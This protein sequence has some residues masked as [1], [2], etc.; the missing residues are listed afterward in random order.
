LRKEDIPIYQDI[1]QKEALA[2][3]QLIR[4][5]ENNESSLEGKYFHAQ[6]AG[7]DYYLAADPNLKAMTQ[8]S[9]SF[10][11]ARVG[12]LS[13]S[14]LGFPRFRNVAVVE[15]RDVTLAGGLYSAGPLSS[16][17]NREGTISAIGCINSYANPLQGIHSFVSPTTTGDKCGT[18]MATPAV[19]GIAAYLWSVRPDLSAFDINARLISNGTTGSGSSAPI[20]DAYATI[21]TADQTESRTGAPVRFAILD[22]AGGANGKGDG[23]FNEADLLAFKNALTTSGAGNMPDYSR[24]DLNGDGYTGGTRTRRFNLN[25]NLTSTQASIYGTVTRKLGATNVTF[26]EETLTDVQILCYYAYGDL[27]AGDPAARG[28]IIGPLCGSAPSATLV[29][30]TVVPGW[31]GLPAS[32]DLANL[33]Q[34]TIPQF[35]VSGSN[36][37]ERGGPIYSSFVDSTATLYAAR[38]VTGVPSQQFGPS[39]NRNNCSSFVAV[40]PVVNPANPSDVK[41]RVWINGTGRAVSFGIGSPDWEYQVR[42]DSG[43]PFTGANKRCEIGTVPNIGNFVVAAT[44]SQC[45]HTL[46]FR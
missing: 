16:F 4:G 39:I 27:Y 19:A 20:L 24:Y 11:F 23:I 32:I 15:S 26:D 1:M 37:E 9:N 13:S 22:V 12:I 8:P 35:Q 42:Y 36:C 14:D 29:V 10:G 25:M 38:T 44:T 31:T 41:T 18:S 30:N 2:W 43:D 3:A 45:T 40:K 17:S 21:L 7:N 34:R 33:V 28:S 46:N 6:A 5:N